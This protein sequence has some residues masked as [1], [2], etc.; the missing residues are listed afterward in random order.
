QVCDK[1]ERSLGKTHVKS[2]TAEYPL[3]G[4][5]DL[6]AQEPTFNV[7]LDISAISRNTL[8]LL[9]RTYG[10]RVREVLAIAA[11]R[12]VLQ[13][14][15]CP[16]HFMIGAQAIFAIE[17][18][19]A[20]IRELIQ[21]QRYKEAEKIYFTVKEQYATLAKRQEDA[22]RKIH[23]DL[24]QINKELLEHLD[25]VKVEMDQKTLI[26]S[27]L[28]MKARQYMQQGNTDKA[29][30]LYLQ[31]REIFKNIPDAFGERKMML[32]NQILTF[33]SQLVNE[34][35][36]KNYGQL[37]QKRDEIM[38]HIEIAT[39]LVNLGNIEEAKRE[40]GLINNLYNEL[41]DG[42]LYEKTLIYKRVL[43]VRQMIDE[44]L[45]VPGKSVAQLS[46]IRAQPAA[47]SGSA[48]DELPSDFSLSLPHD[49]EQE[50]AAPAIGFDSGKAKESASLGVPPAATSATPAEK[51]KKSLFGFMKKDK[52]E[53][54]A[55]AVGV[56]SKK[57]I[58]APPLPM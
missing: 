4:S 58:D 34:F 42:F 41:P 8:E 53:T 5:F 1:I 30:Q 26:I 46:G 16:H 15:I 54:T 23:R 24:M 3:I 29:N 48:S 31:V 20:K 19:L 21:T 52:K 45:I 28:L 33:Y 38:R 57:V 12:F 50:A 22:R 6:P 17:Q 9:M 14:P 55:V 13:N 47:L 27:D 10:K 18:E 35:N 11:R 37:L 7:R 40:Y 49:A 32:E 44:G 51:T 2:K 56:V 43:T 25:K 39:N 36:K